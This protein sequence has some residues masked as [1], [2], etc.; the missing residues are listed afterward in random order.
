MPH[1]VPTGIARSLISIVPVAL[2]VIIFGIA[3]IITDALGAP[4]NDLIGY[5]HHLRI[6][7]H[8]Q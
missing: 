7:F 1:S 4:L 5:K 3:R 2:T 8:H 6:L